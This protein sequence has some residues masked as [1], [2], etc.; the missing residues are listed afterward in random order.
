[1]NRLSWYAVKTRPRWEKKVSTTL[2]SLGF[3]VFCP[4]QK[5]VSQW[6]DRKKTILEPVVRGYVFVRV[7]DENKWNVTAVSGILNYVYW[8]GKPAVIKD[9]E[10]DTL[11]KFFN[12]FDCVSVKPAL[13]LHSKVKIQQ[14]IFM[15]YEGVLIEVYGSK[16]KVNITSMGL[17]FIAH[18]D[19]G[20]LKPLDKQKAI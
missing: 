4:L 16:A 20:N 1:V 11:R 13:I 10:I 19:A 2:A 3:E 7:N 14:G 5:K 8:L 18:F 12:K 15:D 17:E 9:S 6:S